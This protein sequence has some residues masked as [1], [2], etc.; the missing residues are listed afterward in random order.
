MYLRLVLI[1]SCLLFIAKPATAASCAMVKAQPDAWVARKVDALVLA[2]RVAYQKEEAEAAYHRLI[3][4]IAETIR[5]CKL[6]Q[7]DV[8]VARHRTFLDYIKVAALAGLPDHELGFLVPDKQ[9]FE[10][11]RPYVEIPAYLLTQS[12]LWSVSSHETLDRAKAFL[13]QLNSTREPADR[14]IFF[15]YRSQHLGTPDNDDS[16]ERLLI[17]IPGDAGR[18]VPEK[19]VQFGITDRGTRRHIRNLSIVSTVPNAD[20]T[21]NVYFKDFFRTYRPNGSITV[22]GRWELGYGDDNCVKCHKSGVLPIFPEPGSVSSTEEQAMETVNKR[23]LTYG[24]PRFEDYLDPASFGP[25]LGTGT[26]D[27]RKQRFGESFGESIV[28]RSMTCNTCH[29]PEWLGSLNWPMDPVLIGSFIKGGKMPL[30][31]ELKHSERADLY[32]KLVQEY[33]SIDPAN[34]GILK[35]W[36]LGQPGH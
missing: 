20:G 33:F 3:G 6:S 31:S 13:R 34:P 16:Y 36:L 26:L 15:S 18:H 24:R 1:L 19:W 9:Y 4:G 7:D 29:K 25:G 28:A 27:Q 5:Q 23:F 17:V 10:E 14:L 21:S 2:A 35:S 22:K 8:F 32:T 30:G 12:F 11:T